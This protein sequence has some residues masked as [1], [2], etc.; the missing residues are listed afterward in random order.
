MSIFSFA[1]VKKEERNL[2]PKK[3]NPND[4]DLVLLLK[5]KFDHSEREFFH[6]KKSFV[7]D[8]IY[9]HAVPG[10]LESNLILFDSLLKKNKEENKMLNLGGGTGNVSI[11]LSEIGFD[12]YNLDIEVE[13][14]DERNRKFDLN[15]DTTLPYQENFFDYVFCQEVVEHVENPW[16]L[17]RQIN[18]V[19]K[20]NGVLVLT[21]PNIQSALSREKFMQSGYF[22]WFTPDCFAYHINPL[23]KWEIE[24]IAE[25]EGFKKEKISGN[26]EYYFS[27]NK[28]RI[29]SEII[30]DDETI[31]FVFIKK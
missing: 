4:N 12:V 13:N 1:K 28:E 20:K 10:V 17:F 9:C 30:E 24:L 14:P 18:K 6:G 8:S 2:P 7:A 16:K 21:T 25:K 15:T 26:G 23:P 11:I 19:L 5:E 22:R 29:E 27:R 31:I 3:I